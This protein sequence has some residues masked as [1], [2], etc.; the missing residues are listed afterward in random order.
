MS[1]D[2]SDQLKTFHSCTGD[3]LI[4]GDSIDLIGTNYPFIGEKYRFQMFQNKILTKT[5]IFSD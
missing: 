4:L 3:G 1:I 5:K 2:V